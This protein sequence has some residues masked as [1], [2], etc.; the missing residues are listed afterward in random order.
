MSDLENRFEYPNPDDFFVVKKKEVTP[1]PGFKIITDK[2][3]EYH[4]SDYYN[5][6]GTL[7]L[8][9]EGPEYTYKRNHEIDECC[10]AHVKEGMVVSATCNAQNKTADNVWPVFNE[11]FFKDIPEIDNLVSRLEKA[12]EIGTVTK[13]ELDRVMPIIKNQRIAHEILNELCEKYGIK[14]NEQVKVHSRK[15]PYGGPMPSMEPFDY[16]VFCYI[17]QGLYRKG[18][19]GPYHGWRIF[20]IEFPGINFFYDRVKERFYSKNK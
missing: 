17:G 14:R 6:N 20:H 13:P 3:P 16:T 19:P 2:Q 10:V 7:L 11:T 9:S 15:C 8:L 18:Q 4:N 5:E 12:C 1:K